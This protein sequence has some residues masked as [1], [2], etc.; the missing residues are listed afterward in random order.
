MKRSNTWYALILIASAL[1]LSAALSVSADSPSPRPTPKP[2]ESAALTEYQSAQ[3]ITPVGTPN[4]SQ[5]PP[6]AGAPDKK[7]GDGGNAATII[8]AVFTVI[9][10]FATIAIAKFNKQ[11]VSVTDEMRKIS[12]AALHLNRPF[13]LITEV[14]YVR[15][16]DEFVSCIFQN[17]GSGP[18]DIVE[19]AATAGQFLPPAAIPPSMFVPNVT[20]PEQSQAPY[21]PIVSAGRIAEPIR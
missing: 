13:I 19:I 3:Q 11:L 16:T 21:D 5:S 8:V 15:P 2:N 20:Y 10:G 17:S 9:T 12:S 1:F 18:A 6:D 7:E 14:A 4:V